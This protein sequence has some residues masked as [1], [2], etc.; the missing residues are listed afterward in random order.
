MKKLR[1]SL[2]FIPANGPGML[3]NA[4]VFGADAIIFDLEDAVSPA[5]KDSA[6]ILLTNYLT[7]FPYEKNFEVIVRINSIDF[8]D[9]FLADLNTLPLDKIDT[10]M[11]PKAD[12]S[13]LKTLVEILDRKEK[14]LNLSNKINIIPLIELAASLLQVNEIAQEKRVNGL[15]LGAEDLSAD[16][17]FE[18]TTEGEEI[19]FARS[20]LIL[21]AKANKI[22]AIDT[23]YTDIDNLY[24][25][26]NDSAKAKSLGMNAKSAIHP[27]Q[28]TTINRVFSPSKE[29]IKHASAIIDR[30]L[31]AEK[32]GIGVFSYQNKMVDRPIIQRANLVLKKAKAWNLMEVNN[33]K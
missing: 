7:M 17:E 24:G 13:S 22:D 19:L 26:N 23:P 18:R 32:A 28:I 15:F 12:L 29:E 8:Y 27:N 21:A 14:E 9:L 1:R 5:E 30:A 25:L 3:Q 10:I 20:I 16:M 31:E 2:L 6:R 4:D 11:L 33:E